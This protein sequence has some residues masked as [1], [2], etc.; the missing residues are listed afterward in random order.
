MPDRRVTILWLERAVDG[1]AAR[2]H[3]DGTLARLDEA[4]FQNV[5][6]IFNDTDADGTESAFRKAKRI[7]RLL[8][9]GTIRVRT[10]EVLLARFHPA[11]LPVALAWKVAGGSV[12]VSV[13]GALDDISASGNS[14]LAHLPGV[15]QAAIAV[16]RL[17]DELVVGNPTI[18]DH[19]S[20]LVPKKELTVLPNGVF[21]DELQGFSNR[22]R[23]MK[24][25]YAV[26][27]GNFASWQGIEALVESTAS[28]AWP[29]GLPL[30][31]VGDGVLRDLV[32][33][34]VGE[35]LIWIGKQPSEKA[36]AWLAHAEFS[37]SLKRSDT[38]TAQHGYWPFKMLESAALG[39]PIIVS[40]AIGMEDAANE[41][42]NAVV[43][44]SENA[45]AAA[46]AA[47]HLMENPE[48]RRL[49]AKSGLENI[50]KYDWRL[51]AQVLSE[52]ILR[53]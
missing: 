12:V 11:L 50:S 10:G 9:E 38:P 8:A 30:V 46:N 52:L 17:S 49:L 28:D 43:V 40:N 16:L 36:R 53:A 44:P 29:T 25:P 6:S 48:K 42:G 34:A 51:G 2:A 5:R 21:V 26:Y 18:R 4:G 23:P 19:I 7:A 1:S 35:R 33:A 14:P 45:D 24:D 32:Q 41:L 20:N 31:V 3:L 15:R 22:E 39:V 37:F 13:Q 27:V 47:R